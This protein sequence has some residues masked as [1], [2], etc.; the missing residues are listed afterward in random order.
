M[1]DPPLYLGAHP[2]VRL[3]HKAINRVLFLSILALA[4]LLRNRSAQGQTLLY[5]EEFAFCQKVEQHVP[6][7]TFRASANIEKGKPLYIWL[8]IRGDERAL[9]F[10]ETWKHLPIYYGWI[11]KGGVLT[12]LRD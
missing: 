2:W 6:I 5:V 8:K 9:Q 4:C 11:P 10:L 12:G 3:E 1:R 7:G